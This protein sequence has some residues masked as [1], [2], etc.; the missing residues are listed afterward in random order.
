VLDG[1][2]KIMD[3]P[4]HYCRIATSLRET[5]ELQAKIDSY[6]PLIEKSVLN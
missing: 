6:F 3:D 4:G 2:G 1:I 5:I